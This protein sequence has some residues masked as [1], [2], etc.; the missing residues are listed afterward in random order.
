MNQRKSNTNNLIN[1]KTKNK[2]KT[3]KSSNINSNQKLNNS[4]KKFINNNKNKKG[5]NNS[6]LN[7][8]NNS[9]LFPNQN[10]NKKITYNKKPATSTFKPDTDY[11]Y[12]WLTY[13]QAIAYDKR[14][15]CTYYGSLLKNKQL[16]LFTFCSFNDYN[17]GVVKKFMLFLSFALHYTTNALF[18]TEV[19]LHQIYEDEGK[20]NFEYQISKILLSSLISIAVLRLILQFLVLTYKDIL[21]GKKEPTKQM[22]TNMKRN[23]LKCMKIKF[24]IFFILN[25][26]LLTLFWYYLT[27]F[28]AIYK[29]TQVYLI[30][31]TCISFAFS[32]VYPFVINIFPTM[33]RMCSLHSKKKII[34]VCIDYPK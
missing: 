26:I 23:V 1:L 33:F 29:N 4:R 20:F 28:N 24:A 30:E 31:N 11:E 15:G 25:F 19:T 17:S 3:K 34:V 8:R 2:S 12:N 10:N 9:S 18:F 22:A 6:R 21:K 5:N 14:S 7:S 32:L 13:K 27:C 16:I